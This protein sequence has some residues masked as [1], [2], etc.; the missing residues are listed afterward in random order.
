MAKSYSKSKGRTDAP[1]G[2][3]GVP[4]VVM[5]HPDY[6]GLSGNGSKLL[7]ELASQFK[8]KNNGDL[9]AAYGVLKHRGFNSKETVTR[10]THEL[11]KSGL[12]IETR[13]GRFMNP[14]ACCALYALCWQAIDECPGKNLDV[15]PSSK[16]L[17]QI[18]LELKNL[19]GPETGLG[20]SLK[21]GRQQPRGDDGRYSS[22]RKRG[23]LTVVT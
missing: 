20:S 22:P 5:S 6:K 7:F 18:S 11:I 1:G 4:R 8:G 17:R 23:R 10:A 3:S 12:I 21:S 19:P 13:K 2:F 9:T 16:P 14:G 15:A